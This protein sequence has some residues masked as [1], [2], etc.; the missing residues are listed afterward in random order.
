MKTLN[1]SPSTYAPYAR[2]RVIQWAQ[3]HGLLLA[4]VAGTIIRIATLDRL[5]LWLDEAFSVWH[6]RQSTLAIWN[7]LS[8]GHPPLYYL[9]LHYWLTMG[10]SEWWVR[11]PSALLGAA[12]IPLTYLVGVALK[13]A[14]VGLIAAW[15]LALSPWHVWYSQEARMYAAVSFFGALSLL[16]GIRWLKGA[17]PHL[18]VAYAV[19]TLIGLYVDYSMLLLWLPMV[20]VLIW[21]L[22]RHLT[23]TRTLLWSAIQFAILLSYFPLW[24][25]L[26]QH[27]SLLGNNEFLVARFGHVDAYLVVGAFVLPGILVGTGMLW[28]LLRRPG[29]TW[30]RTSIAVFLA[31]L[32]ASIIAM[33]IPSGLTVKRM[34]VI[35]LPCICIAGAWAVQQ[36]DIPVLRPRPVLVSCVFAVLL[37]FLVLQKEPWREVSANLQARAVAGDSLLFEPS[38]MEIPFDYYYRGQLPTQGIS[39]FDFHQLTQMVA[40][41]RRVWLIWSTVE[42]ND[43]LLRWFDQRFTLRE[44]ADYYHVGVRL[45]EASRQ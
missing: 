17:R 45:F 42:P 33:L 6:S 35:Y 38:Y 11:L 20:I 1:S 43:E 3:C 16:C 37:M 8:D 29:A 25:P 13:G 44:Q 18:A 2:A 31:L 32:F 40:Q 12:T 9:A 26:R 34:L 14:R 7:D 23:V 4:F 36:S 22:R 41:K 21:L 5:S 24:E 27:L 28:L 19:S 39:A 30:S 15:L 10:D